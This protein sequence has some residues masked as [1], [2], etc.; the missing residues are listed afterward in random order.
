MALI[1][2]FA[3]FALLIYLPFWFLKRTFPGLA[4]AGVRG[5]EFL[6]H[7]LRT[8]LISLPSATM[9]GIGARLGDTRKTV[10]CVNGCQKKIPAVAV[11]T[12]RGCG[13]RTRRNL[14]AP[15]ACCGSTRRHVRC[16]HCRMSIPRRALWTQPQPPRK[17][18]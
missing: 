9:R 17:Y 16:P 2:S 4:G 7:L 14:Y 11:V 15:C 1:A 5:A 3:L 12:C 8:L 10:R 18:R 6:L 13:Y